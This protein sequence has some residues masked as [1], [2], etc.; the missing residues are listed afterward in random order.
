LKPIQFALGSRWAHTR[1]YGQS[2]IQASDEAVLSQ[3]WQCVVHRTYVAGR[4]H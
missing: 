2:F 3:R 1:R 4:L